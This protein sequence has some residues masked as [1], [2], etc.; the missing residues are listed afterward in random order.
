MAVCWCDRCWWEGS[1][2]KPLLQTAVRSSCAPAA[3]RVVVAAQGSVRH[4]LWVRPV[5]AGGLAAEAAPTNSGAVGWCAAMRRA[6][7]APH[8]A[9]GHLLP[10]MRGEGEQRPCGAGR[11][12]ATSLRCGEKE[13]NVPA[14]RGEGEQRPCGAGRRRAT[15][16]RCGEKE[17]NFPAV[18]GEGQQRCDECNGCCASFPLPV[19]GER[20]PAGRVRGDQRGSDHSQG[21]IDPKQH[22]IVP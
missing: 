20:V 21:I 5:L 3:H 1:R 15:S 18:R 14:V 12:R 4:R 9:F 6:K 10:A 17:S 8:P 19:C 7:S 11:R 22:I 16:P 13:S 2:L